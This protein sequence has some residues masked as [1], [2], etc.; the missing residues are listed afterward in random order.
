M[1]QLGILN[2]APTLKTFI[3]KLP[4]KA[5]LDRYIAM[6]KELKAK[7]KSDLDIITAFMREERQT[8]KKHQEFS[9]SIKGSS[10]E[11][12]TKVRCHGCNKEGHKVAQCPRGSSLSTK[13][14]HATTQNKP[15]PCPA[16]QGTHS[17]T[18]SNGKTYFKNRMSV[19]D[20]FCKKSPAERA[21]IIE[22]A[23]GCALCLD[24]T[25]DHQAKD[26]QAKGKFGK[27]TPCKQQ[28]NG[29]DC[30][31]RHNHLLHGTGNSY[32]NSIKRVMTSNG[33]SNVLGKD[34]PG[35]PSIKEI[36]AADSIHALLQLQ[37]IPVKSKAVKQ[38]STF[39]DPGS[40]VNLVRK[41]FAKEAGWKG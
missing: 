21:T 33:V 3:G 7:K 4:S 24:W 22:Q 15:K 10:K 1:D 17:T 28:I 12:D 6:E 23:R 41:K 19:C 13:R 40:N 26:C 29:S 34:V 20:A 37:L 38:A 39:Y 5:S 25:G 18:D 27:F 30:G 16:C 36:E 14:T 32:C 31:K 11:P 2:H 35:A 9:G 8:Q